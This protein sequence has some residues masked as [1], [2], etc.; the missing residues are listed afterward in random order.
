M[1]H[2]AMSVE[3]GAFIVD[4]GTII[5]GAPIGT[6]TTNQQPEGPSC[7]GGSTHS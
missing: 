3:G 4:T 5:D 2:F 6:N 7:L 1:D